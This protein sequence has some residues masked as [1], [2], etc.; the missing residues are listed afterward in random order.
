MNI[1]R[2]LAIK[3]LK[4]LDENKRFY[5]PFLIVCKEYSPEDDDFI[6][7]FSDDEE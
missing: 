6:D 5:F 7:D 2:E 3:I 1:S 4:Y